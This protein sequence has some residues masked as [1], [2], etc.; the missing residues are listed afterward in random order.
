[1]SA[2]VVPLVIQDDGGGFR[3]TLVPV[4]RADRGW[5]SLALVGAGLCAF[6]GGHG[7]QLFGACVLAAAFALLTAQAQHWKLRCDLMNLEVA[8]EMFGVE[9][10]RQRWPLAAIRAFEV[11]EGGDGLAIAFRSD[12]RWSVQ[13]AFDPPSLADL[14]RRLE[15]A[16]VANARFW[17]DELQAARSRDEAELGRLIDGS[18]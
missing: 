10:D 9:W 7:S 2:T 17:R 14:A 11:L 13:L 16:R 18:P 3:A 1:M 12:P 6:L 8:R 5:A 15:E 4:F